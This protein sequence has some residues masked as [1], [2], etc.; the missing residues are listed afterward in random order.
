M[1]VLLVDVV[2]EYQHSHCSQGQVMLSPNVVFK[3]VLNRGW[4][5]KSTDGQIFSVQSLVRRN[6]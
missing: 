4:S 5:L 6:F 1:V 3:G 2:C